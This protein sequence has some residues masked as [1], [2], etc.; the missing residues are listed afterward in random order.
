MYLNDLELSY[1]Y[2]YRPQYRSGSEEDIC[3]GPTV[4]SNRFL[5]IVDLYSPFI[6]EHAK[7]SHS[8]V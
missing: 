5:Y 1:G 3:V 6:L 8:L 2:G 7:I 4:I